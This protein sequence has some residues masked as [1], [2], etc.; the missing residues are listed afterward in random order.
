VFVD[1]SLQGLALDT[2]FEL[3]VQTLRF[4]EIYDQN[5][6]FVWRVVARLGVR[7]SAVEDV[8]Q[9][10]FVVVH[11][12]LAQFRGDSQIRT[13][14]FQIARL[15]VHEHRRTS[16]RKDTPLGSDGGLTEVDSLP[17]HADASP[18]HAAARSE[19]VKVLHA[20]LEDMDDQKR[21]VFVLAEL[22]QLPVPEIATALGVNLNTVYSRLRLA[23]A[24]F[25][26][27]LVRHQ[28]RGPAGRLR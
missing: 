18:E 20:I 17:T 26:Q 1:L 21:E 25:N 28:A 14:L 23:R 15:V 5:V 8:A 10:V 4:E 19:A 6:D 16:R 22:E 12:K 2:P 7:P 11:K 9:E 3:P 13:W 27:A 24:A